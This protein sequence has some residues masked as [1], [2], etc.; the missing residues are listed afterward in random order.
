MHLTV[1]SVLLGLLLSV[2]LAA[3][4]LHGIYKLLLWSD[5]QAFRR[6]KELDD[7]WDA[8]YL[9]KHLGGG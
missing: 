4:L 6:Q 3:G 7:F 9:R 2:F 5:E 8:D 1:S